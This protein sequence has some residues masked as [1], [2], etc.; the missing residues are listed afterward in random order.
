MKRLVCVA[1][2]VLVLSLAGPASAKDVFKIGLI[3]S[4]TG[5]FA[6]WGVQFQQ[7]VEAFQSVNGK[8][9]KQV[10][11]REGYLFHPSPVPEQT[12][13]S[14]YVDNDRHLFSAGAGAAI[15]NPWKEDDTIDLDIFFQYNL[16]KNRQITKSAAGNV[17]APGY[18]AGGSILLGGVGLALRF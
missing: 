7:A 3:A 5:A 13:D 17:G 4:F 2:A 12:G 10:F 9:V 15:A 16:L 6:T 8:S 18:L 11:F 1:A 14:N